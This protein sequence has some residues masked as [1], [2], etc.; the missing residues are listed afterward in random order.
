VKLV[1]QRLRDSR[2]DTIG[3]LYLQGAGL[4]CFTLED[5]YRRDKV[6]GETRIP[7]G[8]YALELRTANSS[9]HQ[10]YKSRFPFHVGMLQISHVPGFTDVYIHIGNRESDTAGCVLIGD[11]LENNA[12]GYGGLGQST[13]AYERIYPLIASAIQLG[14]EEVRL[15][16]RDE[17]KLEEALW[18]N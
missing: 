3:L 17:I 5:E 6:P 16:I 15:I 13:K 9:M 12:A 10:R 2:N 8:D 11:T 7:P 4:L 18:Q 1:L 14:Q